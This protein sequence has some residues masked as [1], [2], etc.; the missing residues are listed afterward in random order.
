MKTNTLK[1]LIVEDDLLSRLSLKARLSSMGE[2]KEASSKD[3]AKKLIEENTFDLAFVD[4][5]LDSELA[6]L[7][8]VEFLKQKNTYAVVLS[9]REDEFIIEKAYQLGCRDY[10]AKPFTKT[11]LELIFKKFYNFRRQAANT[12]KCA[13]DEVKM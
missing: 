7:D 8:I 6:G 3:E 4:L 13:Q 9:G 2:I 10:L 1:I 5:D 12:L 11:S